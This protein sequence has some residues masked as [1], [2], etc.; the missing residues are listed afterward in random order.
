MYVPFV[1]AAL[2]ALSGLVG[3]APQTQGSS[4]PQKHVVG[5]TAARPRAAR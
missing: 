1:L 4:A 5:Q 3:P 2:L